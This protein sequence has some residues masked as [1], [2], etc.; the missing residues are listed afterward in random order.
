MPLML[1]AGRDSTQ[2]F[3]QYHADA[4]RARAMLKRVS[5]AAPPE[6]DAFHASLLRAAAVAGCKATR[7]HAALCAA[8]AIA[9]A[10][11]WAGWWLGSWVALAGLPLL[12]WLLTANVAHE[13]AHF[14]FAERP[15]VNELLALCSA[16]LFFNTSFWYLQHDVSHHGHTNVVG[17]DI[18]LSH[19]AP[20]ARLHADARWRPAYAWNVTVVA[21]GF[22]VSTLAECLIFPFQLAWKQRYIGDSRPFAR[23]TRAASWAQVALSACVLLRPFLAWGVCAKAAAFALGP[24]L[25]SSI[26]FMSVTQVSHIQH[27]AQAPLPDGVHWARRQVASSVDYAQGSR[28]VTFLTGGLNCQGLHHCLPFMSSSRL[29]DFYPHYRRVCASHG[30]EILEARGFCDATAR[31]WS[32][33]GALGHA[34]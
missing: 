8:V 31:F 32:H 6:V 27:A 7:T 4:G 12:S 13:A 19:F 24:Y 17:K 21:A 11:A 23:Y 2:L 5:G 1:A 26:V 14:S 33:A 9:T 22:A 34:E 3:E 10:A 20:L 30:V 18:D 28:W 25:M 16:P 29:V 15:W